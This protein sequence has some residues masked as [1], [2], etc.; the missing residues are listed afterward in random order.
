[1]SDLGEFTEVGVTDKAV[2][3]QEPCYASQSLNSKPELEGTEKHALLCKLK[4]EWDAEENEGCERSS[5]TSSS[6]STDTFP[7]CEELIC[8]ERVPPLEKY[9][10][11]PS[12]ENVRRA[13]SALSGSSKQTLSSIPEE[14]QMLSKLVANKFNMQ[15]VV[16]YEQKETTTCEEEGPRKKP[17]MWNQ[18]QAYFSRL[19]AHARS[20]PKGTETEV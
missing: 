13:R 8:Q 9:P 17:S 4:S 18:L 10:S 16:R 19:K 12:F 11:F 14:V 7:R 20:A 6:S 2:P 1:M 15:P 3:N 5:I